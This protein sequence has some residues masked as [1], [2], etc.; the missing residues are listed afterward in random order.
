[1]TDWKALEKAL[2]DA[3]IPTSQTLLDEADSPLYAAAVHASYQEEEAVLS[4]PGLAA[5]RR[6]DSPVAFND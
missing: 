5:N 4:V 1:M 3:A 2:F 6:E